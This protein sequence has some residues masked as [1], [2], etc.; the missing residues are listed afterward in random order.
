[1]KTINSI[2]GAAAPADH[3]RGSAGSSCFSKA[4]KLRLQEACWANRQLTIVKH[5]RITIATAAGLLAE[6]AAHNH[7]QDRGAAEEQRSE[8]Q[9]PKAHLA[10]HSI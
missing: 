2:L 5:T 10:A 8:E 9:Q 4:L 6:V 7:R 3:R 1:M